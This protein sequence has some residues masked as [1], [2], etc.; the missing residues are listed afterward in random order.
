[1]IESWIEGFNME[2]NEAGEWACGPHVKAHDDLHDA[3]VALVRKWNSFVPEYNAIITASPR[4]VGRPLAASDAQRDQVL[5]LRKAGASLRGIVNETSLGFQ[6]VRT[7]VEQGERRDRT[8]RK[9]L[10]RIAIDRS[11]EVRWRARKRPR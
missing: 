5:R 8:T 3:H 7:I 11:A 9:Y 4:N 1:L 6:T 10:E 2:Q